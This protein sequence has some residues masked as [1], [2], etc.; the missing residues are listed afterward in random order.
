MEN[1]SGYYIK[2]LRTDKGGEYISR[3]FQNFCKVNGIYKQLT[4]R[5]TPEK[6]GV[7]ERK[8]RT[9]MEMA[10]SM[11]TAKHFSN[12]YWVKA[13]ATAVYILNKCLTKSVKNII[14]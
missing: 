11:L 1:Q 7:A 12:E 14:H 3:E 6:N 10:C 4:V 8:N 13:V 9:I 2:C 5:Y